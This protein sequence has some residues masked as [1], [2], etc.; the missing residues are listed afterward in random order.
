MWWIESTNWVTVV[1]V[2]IAQNGFLKQ[3][4]P[5]R[6]ESHL[7]EAKHKLIIIKNRVLPVVS[8]QSIGRQPRTII[9]NIT[10]ERLK[11]HTHLN[12]R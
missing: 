10:P 12:H 8:R 11:P 7:T 2:V 5:E 4:Q 1:R 6:Q 9:K 3:Q